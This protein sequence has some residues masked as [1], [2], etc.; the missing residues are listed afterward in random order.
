MALG[1]Y[2][3]IVYLFEIKRYE[4]DKIPEYNIHVT[5]FTQQYFVQI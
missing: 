2:F 1:G 3:L 5:L 4:G